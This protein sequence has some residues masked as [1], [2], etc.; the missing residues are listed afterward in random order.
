MRLIA[1][2]KKTKEFVDS[3]TTTDKETIDFFYKDFS[4]C[5]IKEV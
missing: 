2:D 1:H 4:D 5:D 3:I